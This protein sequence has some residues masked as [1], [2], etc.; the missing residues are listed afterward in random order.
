MADECIRVLIVDDHP[1]VR[2]GLKAMMHTEPDLIVVGE[3][4]EGREA[5]ARFATLRPDVTLMDLR[6]PGL[7]GCE[8]TA[9]IWRAFP[10]SRVIML[11]VYDADE[12]VDRALRAGARG[13][14]VK[15]MARQELVGAI[16]RVHAGGR[17][18]PRGVAAR[19]ARRAREEELSP[20]ELGVLALMAEARSNRQIAAELSTTEG[21]VKGY[22]HAVLAKLG[23]GSRVAAVTTALR[24]GLVRL[25]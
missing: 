23:A 5:L 17:H 20:R 16:R 12:D 4:Q 10:G 6:L 3:A 24:R 18:L 1:V 21:T 9:A 15:G 19:L 25:K 2:E 14:L 7:G 13:Y 22:V 8:A 11:T